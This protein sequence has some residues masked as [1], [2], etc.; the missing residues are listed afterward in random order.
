MA[1]SNRKPTMSSSA[2]I[3]LIVSALAGI[4]AACLVWIS[5]SGHFAPLRGWDTA[6]LVYIIWTGFSVL[7]MNA[8]ATATHALRED[9][10][11]TLSDVL[12]IVSSVASLIAVGFL[13]SQT[14]N[15]G[16]TKVFDIFLGL[17]SVIVSWGVVHTI[18]TLK[19]ARLY[20]G[21]P[22]GG[23]D[24]NEPHPP[25]YSDFMYLAFTIGMTFQISDTNLKTK[26]IRATVLKHALL[27][28]VFGTVIIATTINTVVSL[29]K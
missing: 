10:G 20:Y 25:Q 1:M 29:S 2:S 23:I 6:A 28:Y 4:A 5:D 19:Y 18:F 26:D 17:A 11:R 7:P 8:A 9:I 15:S 12:L 3:R 13:I 22:E 24:F 14:G 27:S 16:T 21:E